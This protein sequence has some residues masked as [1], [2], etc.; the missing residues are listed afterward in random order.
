MRRPDFSHST[1]VTLKGPGTLEVAFEPDFLNIAGIQ[2]TDTTEDSTL[3]I[4][5]S[6]KNTPVYLDAL[7]I[8]DSLKAVKG[9][10]LVLTGEVTATGGIGKMQIAATEAGS[11]I[12]AT[13]LGSFSTGGDFAGDMLLTGEGSPPKDLTLGKLSIKGELD[14]SIVL[15][16]GNAVGSDG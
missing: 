10:A 14:S 7:D 2:L 4:K 9:K 13:W 5:S 6:L 16:N 12:E 11:S 1:T 3:T 8:E 15:I